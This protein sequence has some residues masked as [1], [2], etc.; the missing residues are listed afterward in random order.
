MAA[1][2]SELGLAGFRPNPDTTS[3][4]LVTHSTHF[5]RALY[6][7]LC[8]KWTSNTLSPGLESTVRRRSADKIDI[9]SLISSLCKVVAPRVMGVG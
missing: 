5:T 3:V 9:Y 7:L 6:Q 1:C 2:V 8:V 4:I